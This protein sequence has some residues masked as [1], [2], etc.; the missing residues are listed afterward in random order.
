MDD[1]KEVSMCFLDFSKE[2][3]VINRHFFS[4]KITVTWGIF[5][6]GRLDMELPG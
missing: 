1:E 3:D 5:T 6:T 4:V 2:F